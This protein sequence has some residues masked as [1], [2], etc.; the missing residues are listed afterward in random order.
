VILLASY[1]LVA[2]E[3]WPWYVIWSLALAALL[4]TSRPAMLA[5]LLSATVL[6]LYVTIGYERSSQS[7]IFTYRSLPAFVLPLVLFPLL[8]WIRDKTTRRPAP[9]DQGALG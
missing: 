6:S 7:W 4:P 1:W 2:T 9:R 8:I 3:I 5:M